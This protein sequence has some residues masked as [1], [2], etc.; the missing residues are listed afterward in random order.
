VEGAAELAR[1]PHALD[2]L[3]DARQPAEIIGCDTCLQNDDRHDGN[4]LV[5]P[6]AIFGRADH[7]LIPIDWGASFL[8]FDP[9]QFIG[10]KLSREMK[11]RRV[12]QSSMLRT[13]VHGVDDFAGLRSRL[14][15]LSAD[16]ARLREI[17]GR[18]PGSWGVS[19]TYLSALEL[20]FRR[21]IDGVIR[22]LAMAGDPE[23]VFPNWQLNILP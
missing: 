17:L 16:P 15:A 11:V 1:H 7:K 12:T 2:G 23:R 14:G 8:G 5:H 19:T 9:R 22:R 10:T 13:S 3:A 6:S 4:V 21:R 20:H 18:V